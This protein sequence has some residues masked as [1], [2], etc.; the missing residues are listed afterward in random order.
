[1]FLQED[2]NG[3]RIDVGDI[4]LFTEP[5]AGRNLPSLCYGEVQGLT[6]SSIR[7]YFLNKDLSR[8]QR[9]VMEE[10]FSRPPYHIGFDGREF[11][12]S[13]GTGIFEDYEPKAVKNYKDRFYI[14]RKV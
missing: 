8:K 7:I 5:G 9:E 14:V 6:K 12:H 2:M 4:V 3:N 1:M 10:D 11:R 13:I